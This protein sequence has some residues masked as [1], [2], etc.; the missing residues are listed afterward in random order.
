MKE[1]VW[2]REGLWCLESV[3]VRATHLSSY[4][5]RKL[6]AAGPDTILFFVL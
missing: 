4:L 5:R 1:D 3:S 6:T 2:S